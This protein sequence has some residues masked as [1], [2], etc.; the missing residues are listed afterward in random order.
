MEVLSSSRFAR[1]LPNLL[2]PASRALRP[3]RH[4]RPAVHALASS[5]GDA[6]PSPSSPPP[7]LSRLLSAA[8]RGGRAGGEL[9]DLAEAATGGAGIGTLLMST[10]AAAVTAIS[11]TKQQPDQTAAAT[12]AAGPSGCSSNPNNGG[13]RCPHRQTTSSGSNSSSIQTTD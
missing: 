7:W 13:G 6:A 3:A 2:D 5:P 11:A 1:A 10:T 9:P 12:D 8:L 4:R